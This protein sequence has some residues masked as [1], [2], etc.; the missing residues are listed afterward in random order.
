MSHWKFRNEL[1][2]YFYFVTATVVEWRNI[3]TSDKYFKII[4]DSLT[5][6]SLKKELRI[7]A[8]VIMTNHLHLIAKG[9]KTHPLSHIMRDFKHFTAI[10]II[11]ALEEEHRYDDLKIFEEATMQDRRGNSHKVWHEGSHPILLDNA[12]IFRSKIEYLHNNP[13]RKGFAENAE[14]WQ[15]S[16]ASDYI[17]NR[18]GIMPVEKIEYI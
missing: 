10:Q 12:E 4:I 18:P 6:C 11:E 8:F 2:E 14:D 7:A 5:Y 13:V 16:S 17:R 15:Y 9:S 1:D 3:F